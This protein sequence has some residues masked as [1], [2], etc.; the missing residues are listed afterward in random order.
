MH[1]REHRSTACGDEGDDYWNKVMRER[2][3]CGE[4]PIMHALSRS[5]YSSSP[6]SLCAAV[7][8]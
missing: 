2:G 3:S 5:R 4:I 8:V 7:G 1:M 6:P